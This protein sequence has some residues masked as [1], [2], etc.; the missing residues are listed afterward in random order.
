MIK[1]LFA[2]AAITGGI[3]F[4]LLLRT[5]GEAVNVTSNPGPNKWTTTCRYYTPFRIVDISVDAGRNCPK[6]IVVR[7]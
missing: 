6:R 1:W 2:F 3:A 5:S 4:N 7:S